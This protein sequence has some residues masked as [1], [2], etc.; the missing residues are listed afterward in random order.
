MD[1]MSTKRSRGGDDH[2]ELARYLAQAGERRRREIGAILNRLRPSRRW[3]DYALGVIPRDCDIKTAAMACAKAK[4]AIELI[5][6]VRNS[7]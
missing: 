6:D 5:E 2:Y 3:A 7:P 1:Y 4:R